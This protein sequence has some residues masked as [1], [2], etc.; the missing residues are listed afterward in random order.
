MECGLTKQD[1]Q[2]ASGKYAVAIAKV[3]NVA[4]QPTTGSG[5]NRTATEDHRIKPIEGLLEDAARRGEA[6]ADVA[7]GAGTEPAWS[8]RNQGHTRALAQLLAQVFR[9]DAQRL[10]V[11]EDDIG[12]LGRS[13]RHARP[14]RQAADRVVTLCVEVLHEI[15]QPGA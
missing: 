12:A 11:R 13:E 6:D 1:L 9:I 10:N 5:L 15:G 2:V 7:P 14:T 3:R 8:A 4:Q